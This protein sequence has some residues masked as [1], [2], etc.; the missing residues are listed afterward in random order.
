VS[1]SVSKL[2]G[3]IKKVRDRFEKRQARLEILRCQ[4]LE[5]IFEKIARSAAERREGNPQNPLPG[6]VVRVCLCVCVC[7]CGWVAM[8][9]T[10]RLPMILVTREHAPSKR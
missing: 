4:H 3:Y 7:V 10:T 1:C 2:V 9:S 5:R 6:P 8:V